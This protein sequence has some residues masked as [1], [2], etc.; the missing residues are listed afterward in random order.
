MEIKKGFTLVEMAVVLVVIGLI[1]GIGLTAI[2][3]TLGE[4]RRNSEVNK[5]LA[6]LRQGVI[7]VINDN[8]SRKMPDNEEK[9][10]ELIPEGV[11]N[12]YFFNKA[13]NVTGDVCTYSSAN[14]VVKICFD[15]SCGTKAGMPPA[16]ELKDVLYFIGEKG[17][18]KIQDITKNGT[19]NL[20]INEYASG[21]D[22]KAVWVTLAEAQRM[23]NCNNKGTKYEFVTQYIPM[24]YKD[25]PPKREELKIMTTDI[26]GATKYNWCI[27]SPWFYDLSQTPNG[28]VYQDPAAGNRLQF[29]KDCQKIMSLQTKTNYIILKTK[30]QIPLS[31]KEGSYKIYVISSYDDASGKTSGQIYKDFVI[32][33]A[34]DN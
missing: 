17:Q 25:K 27:G 16:K 28:F 20:Q 34:P 18:N 22:D 11:K 12:S 8:E 6:F 5:N 7:S 31:A 1:S 2:I 3:A 14:C 15:K 26:P 13:T 19:C 29:V 24:V 32:S 30:S 33:I 10:L 9:V 4:Q 23:L 21:Y